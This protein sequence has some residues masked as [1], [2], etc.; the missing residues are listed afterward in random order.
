M[1]KAWPAG[2]SW[3]IGP[4]TTNSGYDKYARPE[5]TKPP[6]SVSPQT[7]KKVPLSDRDNAVTEAEDEGEAVH[8]LED[9]PRESDV[10]KCPESTFPYQ[11]SRHIKSKATRRGGRWCEHSG[12]VCIVDV[13]GIIRRSIDTANSIKTSPQDRKPVLSAAYSPKQSIFPSSARTA[14]DTHVPTA[15]AVYTAFVVCTSKQSL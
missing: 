15:T 1:T 3:L 10:K 14:H 4:H 5:Q 9:I 12:G 8:K 7:C 11:Q 6:I 2:G 13:K